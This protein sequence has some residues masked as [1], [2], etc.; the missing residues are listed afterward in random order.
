MTTK[1]KKSKSGTKKKRTL[2]KNADSAKKSMSEDS[3]TMFST[4]STEAWEY[5]NDD[6][7]SY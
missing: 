6:N 1:L 4:I 3:N 7:T 2:S 5:M